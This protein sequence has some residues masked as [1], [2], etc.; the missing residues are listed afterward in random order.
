MP[1]FEVT[2]PDGKKYEVTG[3]EGSTQEQALEHFRS[4]Y[5]E[6]VK[7]EAPKKTPAP[8][9]A[10][11]PIDPVSVLGKAQEFLAK[12]PTELFKLAGKADVAQGLKAPEKA[13][14]RA[15]QY[16]RLTSE[17]GQGA[18]MPW[19]TAAGLPGVAG[20]VA[21]SGLLG[22]SQGT[23]EGAVG[24]LKGLGKGLL[25]GAAGEIL[26]APLRFIQ[27]ARAARSQAADKA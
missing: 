12:G 23:P 18:L 20:R 14:Q 13:E 2:A 10:V 3:P 16:G 21:Q 25:G 17:V 26:A 1:K 11:S 7:A 22:G 5:K 19:G 15:K 9:P 24:G 6:P 8:N 4:Q 27:M